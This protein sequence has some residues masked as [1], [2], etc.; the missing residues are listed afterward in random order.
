DGLS[1][2]LPDGDQDGQPDAYDVDADNDGIYDNYEAQS[3]MDYLAP[4]QSDQDGDGLD[5]R[6]DE[7]PGF[8]G[9]GIDVDVTQ[10]GVQLHDQDRDGQ[11]DYLDKDSDD[12]YIPDSQEAWDQLADGDSRPDDIS[13]DCS[14]DQDKDGLLDCYDLDDTDALSITWAGSPAIDNGQTDSGQSQ[15]QGSPFTDG[16]TLD[17]LLPDNGQDSQEPDFRDPIGDC[18][19]A[20]VAYA[21]EG[22]QDYYAYNESSGVHELAGTQ[23]ATRA[24][25]FCRPAGDDWH[26]YFNP[27]APDQF[28]FAIK[29]S[30]TAS[31]QLALEEW[32]DYIEL[33]REP[34]PSLRYQEESAGAILVMARDWNVALKKDLPQGSALD[35]RFYFE[36]EDIQALDQA[37]SDLVSR[38]PG[39]NRSAIRWFKKEG[40]LDNAD[41][42]SEE[43][44]N[45]TDLGPYAQQV[46]DPS[47]GLASSDGDDQQAGNGKNYIAFHGLTSFSGG[48]AMI[49]VD[50]APLP[51][52]LLQFKGQARG[53][54][55]ALN[56]TTAEEINFEAFEVERSEDGQK[57]QAI[58]RVESNGQLTGGAYY[59]LDRAAGSRNYYRLKM[60]DRDGSFEYS[61]VIYRPS[62][63]QLSTKKLQV[64]PNP[65]PKAS[66]NCYIR[67][68]NTQKKVVL[69]LR[70]A[71]G[72]VLFTEE[73]PAPKGWITHSI[74]LSGLPAGIYFLSN[75][76]SAS[77][78]LAKMSLDESDVKDAWD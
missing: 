43:V 73:F 67:L 37:A 38:Y 55:V 64:H 2:S 42:S 40:G 26:Y 56:W 60:I 65:L 17:D 39:A 36:P 1:N 22:G 3:T 63:C 35:I 8:G 9:Q 5:D 44:G 77:R 45:W 41:I 33:Q 15:S 78:A 51:V 27:L 14:E 31:Q 48:T 74:D 71:T 76:Y 21:F 24:T 46:I 12:D 68:H 10:G 28:L 20:R 54:E 57:F 29:N 23:N 49:Q 6:Y 13:T 34:N 72:E 61:P 30:D 50:F 59:Y 16:I 32:I 7:Q 62:D 52:Q 19:S 75:D 11:P 25:A 4:K 70:R 18:T 47:T 66:A 69:T 53:C 58:E